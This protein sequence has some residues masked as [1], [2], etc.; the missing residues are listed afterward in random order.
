MTRNKLSGRI[1]PSIGAMRQL[2]ELDLG[3]NQLTGR[4]PMEIAS[5][6]NLRRLS[7][8]DN[9]LQQEVRRIAKTFLCAF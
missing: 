8:Y 2:I 7:L 5:L 3:G 1:S 9:K 4:I 6:Q